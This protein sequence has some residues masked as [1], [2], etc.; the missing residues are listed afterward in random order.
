[1]ATM[2]WFWIGVLFVIYYFISRI[3]GNFVF[4]LINDTSL[5]YHHEGGTIKFVIWCP[6]VG[7]VAI[8]VMTLLGLA[9]YIMSFVDSKTYMFSKAVR[10]RLGQR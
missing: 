2:T 1:M 7:E 3:F 8:V 5:E 4:N 6:A 9:G 10:K